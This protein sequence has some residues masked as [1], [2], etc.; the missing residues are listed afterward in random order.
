MIKKIHKILKFLSIT[1]DFYVFFILKILY[2]FL[3]GNTIK[4]KNISDKIS[5]NFFSL[6]SL[7]TFYINL[8]RKIIL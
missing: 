1:I 2:D 5:T 7:I 4:I 8:Y 6:L 3:I